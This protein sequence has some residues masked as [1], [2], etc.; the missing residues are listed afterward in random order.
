MRGRTD[1]LVRQT[2]KDLLLTLLSSYFCLSVLFTSAKLGKKSLGKPLNLAFYFY[3]K[4]VKCYSSTKF[5]SNITNDAHVN[6]SVFVESC[7]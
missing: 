2:G 6:L 5:K 1:A 7:V 3:F 4:I